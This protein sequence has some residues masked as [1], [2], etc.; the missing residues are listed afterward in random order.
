MILLAGILAGGILTADLGGQATNPASNSP[1]SHAVSRY[2]PDRFAGRAG[3]YYPLVWGVD[4]LSVKWTESGEIIRFAYRV[5]DPEKA[6]ILNDKAFEPSLVDPQAGVR[7][8]VPALEQV[9]IL[10]QSAAS[11]GRKSQLDGLFKQWPEGETW[12]PGYR[13]DWP[14][15]GRR[16]RGRLEPYICPLLPPFEIDGAQRFKS[17]L[18]LPFL[19]HDELRITKFLSRTQTCCDNRWQFLSP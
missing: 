14:V 7:L 11:R 13:C 2:Q 1:A 15:S 4:S 16:T 12:R 10:R 8:V 9:G 18:P 3:R 17:G 6:K 5:L 19:D